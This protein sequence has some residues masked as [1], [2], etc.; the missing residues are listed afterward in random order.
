MD[1][2]KHLK[3]NGAVANEYTYINEA[4]AAV[5]NICETSRPNQSVKTIRKYDE[6]QYAAT[7]VA[8]GSALP[9]VIHLPTLG[10]LLV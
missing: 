9:D 7:K 2:Y 3:G 1:A 5:C 8:Y 10:T 6:L 4:D